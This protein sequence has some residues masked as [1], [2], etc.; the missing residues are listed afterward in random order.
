LI[1]SGYSYSNRPINQNLLKWSSFLPGEKFVVNNH[2]NLDYVLKEIL[3][4]QFILPCLVVDGKGDILFSH[5]K[6]GDY[7][8][9]SVQ[10]IHSNVLDVVRPHI[11]ALLKPFFFK[12]AIHKIDKPITKTIIDPFST[13]FITNL[14]ISPIHDAADLQSLMLI[15]FE[16]VK[17]HKLTP[18]NSFKINKHLL[19][20]E[21]ELNITK[22]NLQTTIEELEASNEEM[23]STNEEF[24]SINEELETS[25]EE[26]ESVNEE[27]LI[28]NTE[29]QNRIEQLAAVNDDMNNLFNSTDIAAIFLDN[30]LSIKRFTPQAQELVHIIPADIGRPFKHFSTELKDAHLIESSEDVLKTLTRKTF[31]IQSNDNRWYLT[32]ILP[33]RTLM[34]S[35]DGV[36][37]T[38]VDITQN[39]QDKEEILK[40]QAQLQKMK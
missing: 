10:L 3:I 12:T 24:Q 4:D 38:F 11:K 1:S 32:N 16:K 14:L 30:V 27:L 37:I 15:R 40:L 13:S 36:V 25:K 31:E 9:T 29:L 6:M 35:V 19:D 20:V 39:K 28:V 5:G 2:L 33:Y 17:L 21:E 34:N 18:T 23:Q 22:E 8:S 26:L 7:L